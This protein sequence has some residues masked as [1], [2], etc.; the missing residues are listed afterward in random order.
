LCFS[1]LLLLLTLLTLSFLSLSEKRTT[2]EKEKYATTRKKKEV[3]IDRSIDDYSFFVVRF[4]F[5]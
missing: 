5:L 1:F 2:D 4:S 3:S